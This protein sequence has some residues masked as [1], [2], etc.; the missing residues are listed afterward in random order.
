MVKWNRFLVRILAAA[1][2]L[3]G[4]QEARA[5]IPNGNFEAWS[6]EGE[7]VDWLTNNAPPNIFISQSATAH[8]GTSAAQGTVVDFGGFPLGPILVSG[9]EGVGFPISTRPEALRGFYSLN[10]VGGDVLYI[11]VL[12]SKEGNYIGGG[13][14]E[15]PASG[16]YTEFVANMVY[17]APDVPDTAYIQVVLANAGGLVH[18]GSVFHLDDFAWGAAVTDVRQSPA[19]LP[20][21]F[22]LEQN[23]PNPFNPVTV[24]RYEVPEATDLKL[25]VYDLLGREV[26]VLANERQAPGSYE[27]PFDGSRLASGIYLYSLHAGNFVQTR[28]MILLK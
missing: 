11:V 9:A 10:S 2:L 20:T 23:Y 22:R 7:P 28:R 8:S 18:P 16:A 5:Q 1:A 12:L 3:L 17:S 27:V 21:E 25:A 14:V 24:V 4:I 6:R 15:Q 26:A 13:A 19:T